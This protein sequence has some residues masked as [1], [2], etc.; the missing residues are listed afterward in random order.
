[1]LLTVLEEIYLNM[2]AFSTH[3]TKLFIQKIDFGKV[4]P[5]ETCMLYITLRITNIVEYIFFL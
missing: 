5:Q 2:V 1:M 3:V 4:V